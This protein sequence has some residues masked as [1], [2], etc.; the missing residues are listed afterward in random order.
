MSIVKTTQQPEIGMPTN[1]K[2]MEAIGALAR[3]LFEKGIMIDTDGL[4][5]SARGARIRVSR[6]KM[7]T[8]DGPFVETKEFIG[9]YAIMNVKS[10]EEAVELGKRFMQIHLDF[11]GAAYEGELEVR[12]MA[13]EECAD[14]PA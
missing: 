10:K 2:L 9:G 1:P 12:Q 8:T 11:L 4:L 14:G 7:I 3:E 13:D 5:P 6:G